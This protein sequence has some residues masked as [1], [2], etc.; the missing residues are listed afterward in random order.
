MT[1]DRDLLDAFVGLTDTLV[2]DYDVTD[3]LYRL[4]DHAVHL[5]DVSEAGLL[6]SDQRGSLQVMAATHERARLLELFQL[7]A[8]EGP[9]LVSYRSGEVVVVPD[10]R[11]SVDRWPRFAPAALAEGF[12]AVHAVP[13]RLRDD[14]IGAFNLFSTQPGALPDA[15]LHIA[16]ALADVATISIL[17]ERAVHRRE[18]VI[19]Q[20]EAALNSR[21]I[22]EQAKGVL[23]ERGGVAMDEAF[24]RLRHFA[25]S[26]NQ[27]LAQLA[28][29]V[30][31]GHL[32]TDPILAARDTASPPP[33]PSD[34]R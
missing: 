24:R 6:L 5:L 20:L 13:L 25:R 28:L 27:R 11:D 7:Q 10:L 34:L 4:V 33:R 30:V 15:A 26:S 9:C 18:A 21:V 22:L 3:M 29:E 17:H 12:R 8:D 31:N 16:R 23:A 1:R 19:E 32:D 2:S 14:T